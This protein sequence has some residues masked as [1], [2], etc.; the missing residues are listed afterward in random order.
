LTLLMTVVLI[1]HLQ[2]LPVYSST[3]VDVLAADLGLAY[4]D[5]LGPEDAR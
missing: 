5:I 3:Y 1:P 4:T 2:K